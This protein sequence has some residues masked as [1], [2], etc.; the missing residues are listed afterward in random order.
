ML[1]LI[2]LSC[3]TVVFVIGLLLCLMRFMCC[4][5]GYDLAVGVVFMV[6]NCGFGVVM[7]LWVFVRL[8]LVGL[9]LCCFACLFGD[10]GVFVKLCAVGWFWLLL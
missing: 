8:G 3:H 5:L 6:L 10:C 4:G 2:V 7:C 1:L 9:L